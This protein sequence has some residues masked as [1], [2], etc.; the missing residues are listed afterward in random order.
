[1]LLAMFRVPMQLKQRG[2]MRWMTLA[3][4]ICW[5]WFCDQCRCRNRGLRRMAPPP[6]LPR[7]GLTDSARHVHRRTVIPRLLS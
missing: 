6:P 7:Q 1:M 3:G 2:F 4:P 5:F